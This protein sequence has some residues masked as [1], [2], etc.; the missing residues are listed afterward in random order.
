MDVEEFG[1]M[2]QRTWRERSD[3]VSRIVVKFGV[4]EFEGSGEELRKERDDWNETEMGG[5]SW[6]RRKGNWR[7]KKRRVRRLGFGRLKGGKDGFR[8]EGRGVRTA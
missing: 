3:W 4:V 7:V 6:R 2:T 8:G 1:E 5:E